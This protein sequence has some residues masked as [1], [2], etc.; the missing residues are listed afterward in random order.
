MPPWRWTALV[1]SVACIVGAWT[2]ATND[3]PFSQLED[4]SAVL[5]LATG[6]LMGLAAVTGG[7][8]FMLSAVG[9]GLL[10]FSFR[11][12]EICIIPNGATLQARVLGTCIYLMLFVYT[13]GLGLA[14][15]RWEALG[16][17]RSR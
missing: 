8:R 6:V 15:V 2:F 5:Y 9:A 1:V 11:A 17:G 16:G 13:L 4:W 7:R 12:W 3:A 10:T 14:F